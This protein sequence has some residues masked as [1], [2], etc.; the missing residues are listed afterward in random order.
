MR[1]TPASKPAGTRER[2]SCRPREGLGQAA[3]D[4]PAVEYLASIC[5]S[6]LYFSPSRAVLKGNVKQRRVGMSVMSAVSIP[7][8]TALWKRHEAF[9]SGNDHYLA[10]RHSLG[11]D[12]M[13]SLG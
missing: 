10:D 4:G 9:L 7:S 8:T 3:L 1:G 6:D 5:F 2:Q 12:F 11:P 13:P